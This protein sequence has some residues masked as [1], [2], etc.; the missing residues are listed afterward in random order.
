M[1]DQIT[2]LIAALILAN[3][4]DFKYKGKLL[5]VSSLIFSLALL[6]FAV[7]KSYLLSIF[8]LIFMGSS[9]VTVI[10][11]INTL[12][13][14]KVEHKF[15]GRIMSVFMLTF[16]GLI[17]FGNLIAGSLAEILGVSLALTF[18]G[19]IATIF[20]IAI[21]LLYPQIRQI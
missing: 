4:D 1:Q 16:I 17:P 8:A 2:I 3:L 7:S 9:S 11:L 18:C 10:S 21:N 20:F 14:I 13:Q 6:L 19:L 5:S 12:L 15:R